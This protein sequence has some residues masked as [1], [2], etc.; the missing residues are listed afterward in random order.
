ME[1]KEIIIGSRGSKLAL[2]QSNLV[3]DELKKHYPDIEFKI[4]EIKTKGD[5][6]LDKTF[7]KIGGKGLF[8]KEIE[9]ALLKGEI[10][11]AVHSMKD[12]PSEFPKGLEISA[13]TKREDMRDILITKENTDFY[14]LKKGARIG[15]SSLRRG[16]Q[17][18][19]LR[20]D[21]EIVPVRG[22][23]QT[24]IRKIE[25]LDLDGVIL[26]AAGLSR[27]GLEDQI[28]YYFNIMDVIPAVGQ[29]ALGIETR[30][31][32]DFV[33]EMTSKINDET[34]SLAI[35][36]ERM[37]MKILNGGCHVPIGAFAFIE[38]EKLKMVGTVAS[39]DGEKQI[40]VSGE[41]KISGYEELGKMIAEEVLDRGGRDILNAI[42]GDN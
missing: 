13:I 10:D 17:L 23:V 6:I 9:T 35:K 41:E 7:D 1:R 25:E 4:K 14:S 5:K 30:E 2:V 20:N 31:D 16:A 12:V 21:I 34:T 11:I 24:R 38:E 27:L 26:A 37:F 28:S 19:N 33:K 29:G 36:A 42:E 32:D 3:I 15:T 22:N 40:K 8:V 18:K 39:I